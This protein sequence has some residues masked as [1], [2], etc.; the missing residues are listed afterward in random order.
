MFVEKSMTLK[1]SPDSNINIYSSRAYKDKVNTKYNPQ[2][3]SFLFNKLII[4]NK[5]MIM[6]NPCTS[7]YH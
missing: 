4:D 5:S 1:V 7:L 3:N 6:M 2:L